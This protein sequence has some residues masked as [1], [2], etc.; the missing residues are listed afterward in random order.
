MRRMMETGVSLENDGTPGYSL[1]VLRALR[2]SVW[3]ALVGIL[4]ILSAFHLPS[5]SHG[6]PWFIILAGVMALLERASYNS[7]AAATYA[8]APSTMP[9]PNAPA[10]TATSIVPSGDSAPLQSDDSTKGGN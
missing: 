6:W 10:S 3:I 4:L 9:G 5:W 2:L 1:R 8:H 7:A